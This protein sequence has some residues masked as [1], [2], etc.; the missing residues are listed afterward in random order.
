[1][2]KKGK[3]ILFLHALNCEKSESA[4]LQKLPLKKAF[5]F[6]SGSGFVG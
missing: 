1:M 3:E 6:A 2:I 4:S 5:C